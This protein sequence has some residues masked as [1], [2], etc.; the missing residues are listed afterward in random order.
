[1]GRTLAD[2]YADLSF[3]SLSGFSISEEASGGIK[4]KDQN[5]L[6]YLIN[7]GLR[8]LYSRFPIYEK[9]LAIRWSAGK[10]LYPLKAQFGLYSGAAAGTVPEAD[11][12]I[13][14]DPAQPFS[15][16]ILKFTAAFDPSGSEIALNDAGADYSV[17]TP[18][19]NE[20][21][22]IPEGL[23]YVPDSVSGVLT[24]VKDGDIFL[25]L[26]QARHP[27]LGIED[28][29]QI[30]RLPEALYPALDR[31]VASRYI[32]SKNGQEHR[33]R[34]QELM[35]EYEMH[36]QMTVINDSAGTS[37]TNTTSKLEDRG[38]V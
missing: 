27:L 15:N 13:L 5:R 30:V 8:V 6:V 10:S 16:D 3:G 2:I 25:F 24:E 23:E 28:T 11:R 12:Y 14:D 34:G 18:L 20:V 26:Y 35:A 36:C 22:Q 21:L 29:S 31:Y 37:Q 32:S 38:F 17:F 7:E 9:E 4:V 19:S 33:S 1:M